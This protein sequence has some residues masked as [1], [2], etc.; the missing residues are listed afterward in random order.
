MKKTLILTLS[1]AALFGTT[2]AYS[3]T[4]DD[5]FENP[6]TQLAQKSSQQKLNEAIKKR[7]WYYFKNKFRT[8]DYKSRPSQETRRNIGKREINVSERSTQVTRTG[9]LKDVPYYGDRREL[10]RGQY[11]F[12]NN[13]KR[14][15]RARAIDYYVDGGDANTESM[16]K[17]VIYGS[18]HR[19]SRIPIRAFASAIGKINLRNRNETRFI[20]RGEQVPTGY[21]ATSFRRGDSIRNFMHPY[22]K[23]E[24]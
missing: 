17:G 12:P 14:N 21:Q 15:F 23:F 6:T 20:G 18:T 8:N 3:E 16:Q 2:Y 7:Q 24:D 13:S 4:R 9:A 11:S 5:G 10:N 19:V 1:L 22:M